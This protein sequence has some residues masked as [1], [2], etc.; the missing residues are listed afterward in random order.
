MSFVRFTAVLIVLWMAASAV[1]AVSEAKKDE[2]CYPTGKRENDHDSK[3]TC[4]H[5]SQ[6]KAPWNTFPQVFKDHDACFTFS[7]RKV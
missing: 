7:G 6:M 5:K 4:M 1:T 2:I 3:K